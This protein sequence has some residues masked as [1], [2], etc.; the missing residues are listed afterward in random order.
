MLTSRFL[1][2]MNGTLFILV[3]FAFAMFAL[4]ITR[5]IFANGFIRTRLQAAISIAVFLA[6]EAIIRGWV[7]WWRHQ[8][9]AGAD[10]SWMDHHPVL[11]LGAATQIIGAVCMIRVFAPDPWGR[12]VWIASALLAVGVAWLFLQV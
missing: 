3:L 8:I 6:G 7:W 2:G 1:E 9:N 5:E 10:S 12:N 4:Y 11:A